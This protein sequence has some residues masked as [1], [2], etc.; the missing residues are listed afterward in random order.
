MDSSF[1][2]SWQHTVCV[3]GTKWVDNGSM[4]LKLPEL[5]R[6]IGE[7]IVKYAVNDP[8]GAVLSI[9]DVAI[10][11]HPFQ[12]VE[13]AS[14]VLYFKPEYLGKRP[15][16]IVSPCYHYP[17]CNCCVEDEEFV[18]DSGEQGLVTLNTDTNVDTDVE[19]DVES[20]VAYDLDV[21]KYWYPPHRCE[22]SGRNY[23][24]HQVI[25]PTVTVFVH[26]S[27]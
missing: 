5:N 20:N 13:Q 22:R 8:E 7:H 18:I 14:P 19:S 17:T 1:E 25:T 10:T 23:I 15:W 4:P 11:E 3:S 16:E 6:N 24:R 27:K 2:Y 9:G 21:V 12:L 26:T